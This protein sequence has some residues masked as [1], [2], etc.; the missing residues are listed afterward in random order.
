MPSLLQWEWTS[1][2]Y[3]SRLACLKAHPDF[4]KVDPRIPG[5]MLQIESAEALIDKIMKE[6]P[7]ANDD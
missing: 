6:R 1:D 5:L 7:D 4:Q 3:Y 2:E